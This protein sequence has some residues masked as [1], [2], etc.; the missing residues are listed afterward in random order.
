MSAPEIIWAYPTEKKPTASWDRRNAPWVKGVF[1]TYDTSGEHT[2]PSGKV[3]Y[4]RADLPP[5]DA[6]VMNHPKVKAL[7]DALE[8]VKTDLQYLEQWVAIQ[9]IDAALAAI[10]EAKP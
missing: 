3:A 5:T 6:E 4:R 7:V 10:Q 8:K 1:T 2:G 9:E